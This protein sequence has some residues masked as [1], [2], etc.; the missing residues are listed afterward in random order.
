MAEIM[1]G[2]P[3]NPGLFHRRYPDTF[4]KIQGIDGAGWV[5][6]RRKDP[7][8]PLPRIQRPHDRRRLHRQPL[9]VGHGLLD[10]LASRV[11][12]AFDEHRIA[13]VTEHGP[14]AQPARPR[15]P[16]EAPRVSGVRHPRRHRQD[17]SMIVG[18]AIRFFALEFL[19][20]VSIV[21][22]GMSKS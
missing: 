21:S 17:L 22:H 2:R 9:Q 3:F 7:L 6:G 8:R 5:L 13:E 10:L 15:R 14:F 18:L 4:V 1:P 12:I 19:L 11:A 16:Q 20:M